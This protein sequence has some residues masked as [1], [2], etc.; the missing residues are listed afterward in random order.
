L[1]NAFAV[2][3]VVL[4]GHEAG[5]LGK[6]TGLPKEVFFSGV[7]NF[8][9]PRNLWI[10]IFSDGASCRLPE[11]RN[12]QLNSCVGFKLGKFVSPLPRYY[13]NQYK[14]ASP[15]EFKVFSCYFVKNA[16]SERE[17]NC[18]VLQQPKSQPSPVFI[19]ELLVRLSHGK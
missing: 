5:P 18:A 12:S 1:I 3:V 13:S 7:S 4:L 11:E 9:L 10:R 16:V 17:A 19:N 15:V 6:N 14:S 8:P 2:E